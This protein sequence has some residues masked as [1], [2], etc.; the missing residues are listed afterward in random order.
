MNRQEVRQLMVEGIYQGKPIKGVLEETNISWVILSRRHAFKIKKDIKLSFLDYS[1][2]EL[3]K[4]NCEK[5]LELNKRFSSI[6]LSVQPV[7]YFNEQFVIGDGTGKIVDYVVCMKRMRGDKRMDALLAQNKVDPSRISLLAKQVAE[8]HQTAEII[9]SEF[10]QK[11]ARE[12]F[13]DLITVQEVVLQEFETDFSEVI[14]RLISFSDDFLKRHAGRF[15]ERNKQ[16]FK[17]DVHGDLHSGN[18]FLYKSPVIFDCI[19]FQDAFRQIDILYEIAFL[20]MDLEF[21]GRK[22]LSDLFLDAYD[23][24][25]T[26]FPKEVDKEIFLYFKSL[27]ANVRAKVFLLNSQSEPNPEKKAQKLAKGKKYL[28]L[29]LSYQ[30]ELNL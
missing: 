2:L 13:N 23:A 21:F 3:R 5:E 24:I 14:P 22:D 19:E 25:L 29:A 26:S 6:Y 9:D 17:R 30:V 20:C 7:T 27:R 28:E 1:T 11:Q 16:G 8:F 4:K 10:I 12:L 15:G 18:I